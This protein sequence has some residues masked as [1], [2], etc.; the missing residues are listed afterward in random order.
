MTATMA[1]KLIERNAWV[2]SKL[3]A[4]TITNTTACN[5][6]GSESKKQYGNQLFHFPPPYSTASCHSIPSRSQA[7]VHHEPCNF[8]PEPFRQ[9]FD[10]H[11]EP[12]KLKARDFHD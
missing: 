12:L 11:S 9:F 4:T 7:F 6:S 1:I 2:C 8:H 10:A 5:A 3:I